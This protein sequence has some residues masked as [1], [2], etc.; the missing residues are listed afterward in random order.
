M[1]EKSPARGEGKLQDFYQEL[2]Q[3][4]K[5]KLADKPA[6][7][8]V[9]LKLLELYYA[10]NRAGE[11]LTAAREFRRRLARPQLSLEWQRVASMGRMLLP[12]DAL[13]SGSDSDR[14]EFIGPVTAPAKAAARFQRFGEDER[15]RPLFE[16]LAGQYAEV[17]KDARFLA[18]LELLIVGP[19]SRRPTPLVPA[20]RLSEEVGGA[21][22]LIK[23]EDLADDHS[24]LTVAVMGQLLLALRLGRK[25]VVTATAD[26]RR[27]VIVASV[28]AR[29][30][31]QAVVFMDALQA[32]RSGPNVLFMKLLGAE[33]RRV[34]SS[35][36]RGRDVRE[37]ALEYWSQ[38]PDET[39]LVTALD[40]APRPYPVMTEE[41]TAAI[42][43][44]CRRQL[45][46]PGK[47]L[48]AL[49]VARGSDTADALGLFPAF[50][51][52]AQ[53]RL[54]CV[55]PEAE[56]DAAA[57]TVGDR[58]NAT[59]M[60][61]SAQEKKVVHGILDRLEYPGVSREHALL[62]AS[63]RVEYV[64]VR[65][66]PAREALLEVARLEGLIM[67]PG[68]AHAM[69]FTMAEA[70]KLGPGQSVVMLLAEQVDQAGWDIRGLVEEAAKNKA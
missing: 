36:Y 70:R 31:L 3:L 44:E 26:G 17:R 67:P 62:K 7:D 39:F 48:P 64:G 46:G 53:T 65:R 41:F 55:E 14:I 6:L 19:P 22:I 5:R 61:M 24:H 33:L 29:L 56:P 40:A 66:G 16:K 57:R 9:C 51:A 18:N 47:S 23:R 8:D 45:T 38:N 68:S 25:S 10:Q 30:G 60:P 32:E 50:F 69:A 43:R 34:K 27:G 59:G 28:A 11:F 58:F 49:I 1:P 54:A 63:G 35:V 13:F 2:E 21:Q 42:G 20:R 37:A 12:G 4:L 52:D 15:Y